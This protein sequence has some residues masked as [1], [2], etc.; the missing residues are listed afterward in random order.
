M[1]DDHQR[2]AYELRWLRAARRALMARGNWRLAARLDAVAD[3]RWRALA[4]ARG[5]SIED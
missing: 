3:R 4:R 2:I 5:G 1:T